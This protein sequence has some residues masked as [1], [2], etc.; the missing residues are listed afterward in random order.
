MS[1]TAGCDIVMNQVTA[2][3]RND[4]NMDGPLSSAASSCAEGAQV[5]DAYER[6]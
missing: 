3:S 2:D 1:A 4:S 6:P 5:T